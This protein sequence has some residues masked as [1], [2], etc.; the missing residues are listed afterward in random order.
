M[1]TWRKLHDDPSLWERYFVREKV[2]KAIRAFFEHHEFHEV[3]TPILCPHPPAESYVDVLETTLYDQ[4]RKATKAYLYTS[5]EVPL[6]KLLTA[7]IG[8]CFS[9]TKTFRNMEMPSRLHNPEFTMLEW[10]RVGADYRLA[11]E[12]C[13]RLLVSLCQLINGTEQLIYQ[14]ETIDI[15][16]PWER[17][18]VAEAFDRWAS[19]DLYNFF[20]MEAARQIVVK[21]GYT[22]EQSNTW[23]Q[24]YNQIFLNEVE[25]HLGRGKPT[26]LYDFP[27]ISA[28]QCRK[29]ASD[30]RFSERFEFYIAGLELGDCYTELTDGKEQKERFDQELLEVKRLGKTTYTYD[31]DFIDALNVGL[32][33]CSGVAVGVDR[34]IMLFADVT[35]IADTLFFPAKEEFFEAQ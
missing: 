2:V 14:G 26:I 34:L 24:W 25:S 33:E 11:M 10:Y 6:K 21:K 31:T 16:Q 5:P 32:P 7:G 30:P 4:T 18:S 28:A 12:D 20:D 15:S 1:K 9:L 27:A 17:L 29:K 35:D 8:N 3:E 19:V 22:V 23:E 13:E